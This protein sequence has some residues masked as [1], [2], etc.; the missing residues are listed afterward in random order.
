MEK[1][2]VVLPPPIEVV[3]NL[4]CAG[5]T[6]RVCKAMQEFDTVQLKQCVLDAGVLLDWLSTDLAMR[7]FPYSTVEKCLKMLYF[8]AECDDNTKTNLCNNVT[9]L[10]HIVVPLPE[11]E[12]WLSIQLAFRRSKLGTNVY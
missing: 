5:L 9:L 3:A 11:E 12:D 10:P 2:V 8:L 4:A 6:Q 7:Y 1:G